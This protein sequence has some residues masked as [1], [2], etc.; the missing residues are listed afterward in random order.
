MTRPPRSKAAA[1]AGLP[2]V[3]ANQAISA[4]PPRPVP[5]RPQGPPAAGRKAAKK[6]RA[7]KAG[8]SKSNDGRNVNRAHDLG[9]AEGQPEPLDLPLVVLEELFP[10]RIGG[11]ELVAE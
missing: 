8:R 9:Q 11:L 1:P 10:Q 4:H 5:P 2:P 3:P 7:A 6:P